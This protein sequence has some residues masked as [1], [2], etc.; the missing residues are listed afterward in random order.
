MSDLHDTIEEALL[1][2]V[3]RDG[4]EDA[5][6]VMHT[7]CGL[8]LRVQKALEDATGGPDH[9]LKVEDNDL[10]SWTLQHPLHERFDGT[11]F[12][13]K[14]PPLIGHLMWKERFGPGNYRIYEDRGAILWDEVK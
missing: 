5:N 1:D 12:D 11:L 7:A 4:W 8:A 13:C 2:L 9:L 3:P 10:M 6:G 14:F